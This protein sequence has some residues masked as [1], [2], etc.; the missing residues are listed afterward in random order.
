MDRA[1]IK[2]DRQVISVPPGPKHHFR[3]ELKRQQPIRSGAVM[4]RPVLSSSDFP[5]IQQGLQW[6][7]WNRQV[8]PQLISACS[9]ERKLKG[10]TT[11]NPQASCETD[12]RSNLRMPDQVDVI[13]DDLTKDAK[14]RTDADEPTVQNRTGL[15]RGCQG[16]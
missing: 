14:R 2:C 10:M 12:R 13:G 16:P 1:L 8:I 4:E 5:S 6:S 9:W 3:L 15:P 7:P 11:L